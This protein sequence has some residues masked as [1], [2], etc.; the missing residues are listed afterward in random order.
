MKNSAAQISD[1]KIR[2]VFAGSTAFTSVYVS[3]GTRPSW[4]TARS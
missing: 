3:P 4:L 2:M 1:T